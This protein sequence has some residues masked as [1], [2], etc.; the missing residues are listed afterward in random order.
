MTDPAD[1]D[2]QPEPAYPEES[3]NL[4]RLAASTADDKQGLD[5]I[6]IPV[7]KVLSITEFFVI[8]SASNRRLVRAIADEVEQRIRAEAGRSPGRVEGHRE[9]QWVLLDYGDVVVHVFLDEMR[10]F[11]EIERLYRDVPRV[12]WRS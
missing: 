6:V 7:G 3:L 11:Y 1:S 12:D 10:Q 8:T 4:A 2:R 9:Q 5:T